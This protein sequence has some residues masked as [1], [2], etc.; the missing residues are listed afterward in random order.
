MP[1]EI[2]KVTKINLIGGETRP[3][4]KL[5]SAGI[6]IANFC[7]EFN[8]ATINRKGEVVPTIITAYTDKS[9]TFKVKKTTVSQLLFKAANISKG[10]PNIKQTKVGKVTEKQ[11]E[12]I[13]EYKLDELNCFTVEKAISIISAIAH[14]IGLDIVKENSNSNK[15]SVEK[16]LQ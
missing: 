4:P 7:K 10:S 13:A 14:N 12:E 16:K 15:N 3:G 1:K 11:I 5:S 2:S 9:F 8:A 6:N